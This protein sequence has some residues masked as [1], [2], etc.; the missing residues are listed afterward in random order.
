MLR[1]IRLP[2]VNRSAAAAIAGKSTAL[3]DNLSQ[4]VPTP[5]GPGVRHAQQWKAEDG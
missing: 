3:I 4:E 1:F 2:L 5:T